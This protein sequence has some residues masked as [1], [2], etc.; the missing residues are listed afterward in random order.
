MSLQTLQYDSLFSPQS[1]WPDYSL[2]APSAQKT[3]DFMI[4]LDE[5]FGCWTPPAEPKAPA[6][7]ETILI[8]FV[9]PSPG[10]APSIPEI[11]TIMMLAMG[12]ALMLVKKR[13]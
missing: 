8:P 4:G 2:L 9:P 7:I 3:A 5:L 12:L 6:P 10:P 13:T 1:F 11:P